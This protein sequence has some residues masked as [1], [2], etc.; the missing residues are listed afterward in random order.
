MTRALSLRDNATAPASAEA[1]PR[2]SLVV[3]LV[4]GLLVA[5]VLIYIQVADLDAIEARSLAFGELLVRLGEHVRLV[6]VSTLVVVTLGVPLGILLSRPAAAP[7]QPPVLAV[8][9]AGQAI[10]S[11]GILV[12]LALLFDVG[13]AMAVI[14][15]VVY[16]LLPVLRN[17]MVGLRHVDRSIIDAARGMGMGSRRILFTVELPLAVPV[18]LAGIRVALILN[19]GVATLATYTDA[20]GLGDLI[21]RGI[22]FYRMPILLSGCLLTIALA[23]LVDW[24]AGVAETR[25]RPRG[26]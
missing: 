25:L 1:A 10:P 15:L 12:L 5:G 3:P 14:S 4:A 20:G 16:A 11:I 7:L 24:L 22:V 18:M 13:F 21:E 2:S 8:A 6:I 23:L 9:N 26:L 17:T 19:V